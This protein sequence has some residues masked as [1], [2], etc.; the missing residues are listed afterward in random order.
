MSPLE[1]KRK[2]YIKKR[3]IY[4]PSSAPFHSF[5]VRRRS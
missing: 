1:A 5:L 3:L 2:K 4:V